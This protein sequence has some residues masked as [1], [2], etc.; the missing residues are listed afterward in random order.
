LPPKGGFLLPGDL[1]TR[2]VSRRGVTSVFFLKYVVFYTQFRKGSM[3]L[4]PLVVAARGF[5]ARWR[6]TKRRAT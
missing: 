3:Q 6:A 4:F 5:F 1:K 2:I